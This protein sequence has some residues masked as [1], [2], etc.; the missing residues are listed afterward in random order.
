MPTFPAVVH[1]VQYRKCF[2][3]EEA[4][5]KNKSFF[6]IYAKNVVFRLV[7]FVSF[8]PRRK[9]EKDGELWL[10]I[11]RK[12]EIPT[13]SFPLFLHGFGIML[14]SGDDSWENGG[15]SGVYFFRLSPS[16]FLSLLQQPLHVGNNF[17][18]PVSPLTT[19]S[20]IRSRGIYGHSFWLLP[21]SFLWETH[22]GGAL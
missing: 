14:F 13:P 9:K 20:T 17:P 2:R 7:F 3:E 11:P 21:D 6:G 18:L 10:M 1:C 19:I 12:E 16:S 15:V 22:W 8:L 5:C 4:A